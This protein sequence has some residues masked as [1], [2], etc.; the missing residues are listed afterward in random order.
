MKK[1]I[2]KN[3][4]SGK[5]YTFD[6]E[7]GASEGKIFPV[8]INDEKKYSDAELKEDVKGRA[9]KV[10]EAEKVLLKNGFEAYIVK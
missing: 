1:A 5:F 2:Y 3:P 6:K 7:E 4:K 9:Y 8:F 10:C